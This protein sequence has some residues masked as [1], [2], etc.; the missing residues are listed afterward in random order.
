MVLETEQPVRDPAES[1]RA[2]PI[3]VEKEPKKTIDRSILTEIIYTEIKPCWSKRVTTKYTFKK[4]MKNFV[5]ALIVT[6]YQ[7]GET[8]ILGINPGEQDASYLVEKNFFSFYY[9]T[10]FTAACYIS[11]SSSSASD[12]RPWRLWRGW[13]ELFVE[14]VPRNQIACPA[15]LLPEARTGSWLLCT[16]DKTAGCALGSVGLFHTDSLIWPLAYCNL[17]CFR[18]LSRSSVDTDSQTQGDERST[19]VRLTNLTNGSFRQ[20]RCFTRCH[21]VS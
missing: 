4:I 2:H 19:K 12:L 17:N 21:R 10:M 7:E 13:N 9:L 5:T 16:M 8:Q 3:Q 14:A 15:A 11:Y 1:L 6:C 20:R 18:C